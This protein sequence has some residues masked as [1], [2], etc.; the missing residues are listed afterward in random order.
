VNIKQI[1][2][3]IN[4]EQAST[5]L[6]FDTTTCLS[7]VELFVDYSQSDEV[8]N[9]QQEDRLPSFISTRLQI[10]KFMINARK[11]SDENFF[12]S[13]LDLRSKLKQL[14]NTIPLYSSEIN[15]LQDRVNKTFFDRLLRPLAKQVEGLIKMKNSRLQDLTKKYPELQKLSKNSDIFNILFLDIHFVIEKYEKIEDEL[16]QVSTCDIGES[17][18]LS[19][20]LLINVQKLLNQLRT[21]GATALKACPEMFKYLSLDSDIRDFQSINYIEIVANFLQGQATEGVD[22]EQYFSSFYQGHSIFSYILT[23]NHLPDIVN[24]HTYILEN[25]EKYPN[26]V[27]NMWLHSSES[28]IIVQTQLNEKLFKYEDVGVAILE[29][30]QKLGL[31]ETEE[32]FLRYQF[33]QNPRFKEILAYIERNQKTEKINM[34]L[35]SPNPEKGNDNETISQTVNKYNSVK[36]RTKSPELREAQSL[37][38]S[39]PGANF[40]V[41]KSDYFHGKPV[42][43]LPHILSQGLIAPIFRRLN[44]FQNNFIISDSWRQSYIDLSHFEEED[45]T[46]TVTE[47]FSH[48]V[49]FSYAQAQG[50]ILMVFNS[51]GDEKKVIGR[52]NTSVVWQNHSITPVGLASTDIRAIILGKVDFEIQNKTIYSVLENKVYIPIYDR[53]GKLIFTFEDYQKFLENIELTNTPFQF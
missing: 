4:V 49:V 32:D 5:H 17:S 7:K 41:R 34:D 9:K 15:Q 20:D 46:N 31:L 42:S 53:S 1:P 50:D 8:I 36:A 47:L 51:N 29:M 3:D 52:H 14:E 13:Y 19:D 27:K 2:K 23:F 22:I 40:E 26:L 43:V 21:R 37:N 35:G 48:K 12:E 25:K 44:A 30:E 16:W 45:N 28:Q 38:N 18:N 11:A 33:D 6:L 24:P 39:K 10:A